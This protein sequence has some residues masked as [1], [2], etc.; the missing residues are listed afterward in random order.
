MCCIVVQ[1][2]I[3]KATVSYQTWHQRIGHPSEEVLRKKINVPKPQNFNCV[4]CSEKNRRNYS[5]DLKTRFAFTPAAPSLSGS[6]FSEL[7][8]QFILNTQWRPRVLITDRARGCESL[9][10]RTYCVRENIQL[11]FGSKN[12]HQQNGYTERIIATL[13]GKALKILS[14]GRLTEQ[15]LVIVCNKQRFSTIDRIIPA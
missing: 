7:V 14:T 8:E 1:S 5:V 3:V 10:F 13:R 9:E 11:T 4:T 2:N 15:F 12:H 6:G